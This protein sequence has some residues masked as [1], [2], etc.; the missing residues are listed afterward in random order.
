[1]GSE[2]V[3]LSGLEGNFL[4]ISFAKFPPPPPPP[5]LSRLSS[6]IRERLSVYSWP[7]LSLFEPVVLGLIVFTHLCNYR[8]LL[9]PAS[10]WRFLPWTR[11]LIMFPSNFISSSFFLSSAPF[12]ACCLQVPIGN[13]PSIDPFFPASLV[14]HDILRILLQSHISIS[15]AQDSTL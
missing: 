2:V 13:H 15:T 9:F 3:T 14:T 6:N 4:S 1:M 5:G 7:R 12:S 11:L 8:T 10:N